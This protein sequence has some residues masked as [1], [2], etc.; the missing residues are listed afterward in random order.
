MILSDLERREIIF[1][2][3]ENYNAIQKYLEGR[4]RIFEHKEILGDQ[5]M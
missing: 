1:E 4:K 2:H 5:R 3:R